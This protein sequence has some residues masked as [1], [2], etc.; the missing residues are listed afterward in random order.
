M[1]PHNLL[2]IGRYHS[3]HNVPIR[4][5]FSF[6]LHYKYYLKFNLTRGKSD[7]LPGG[8]DKIRTPSPIYSPTGGRRSHKAARNH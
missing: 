2:L 7:Q 4:Y 5:Y 3:S 1:A 8:F 6:A